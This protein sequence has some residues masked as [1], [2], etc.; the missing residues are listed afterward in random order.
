MPTIFRAEIPLKSF[1]RM[2]C[3]RGPDACPGECP[4]PVQSGESCP[5][6]GICL[7]TSAFARLRGFD[8]CQV[9]PGGTTVQLTRCHSEIK[10]SRACD[11]RHVHRRTGRGNALWIPF[12]R[13]PDRSGRRRR[14]P[15]VDRVSLGRSEVSDG[16]RL[17]QVETFCPC[18]VSARPPHS[19]SDAMQLPRASG[20]LFCKARVNIGQRRCCQRFNTSCANITSSRLSNW[21]FSFSMSSRSTRT[22]RSRRAPGTNCLTECF[23]RIFKYC[24]HSPHSANGAVRRRP[25]S[26][27]RMSELT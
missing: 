4:F 9:F 11:A 24:A 18:N 8:V 5:A 17:N 13:S 15:P 10:S 19:P 2:N 16:A 25:L 14:G 22:R 27:F 1:F 12:T 23:E 26:N 3:E 6:A 7:R 21:R 20:P